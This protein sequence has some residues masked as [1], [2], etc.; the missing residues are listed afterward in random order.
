MFYIWYS[1]A[2]LFERRIVRIINPAA[3]CGAVFRSF[4]ISLSKSGRFFAESNHAGRLKG[5][6]W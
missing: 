4:A 2:D 3:Y 1:A 6:F 5:I